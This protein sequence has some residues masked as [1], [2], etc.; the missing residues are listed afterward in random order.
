[1]LTRA[2]TP[3]PTIRLIFL[4]HLAGELAR[5]VHNQLTKNE[6]ESR[7]QIMRTLG[8]L[9]LALLLVLSVASPGLARM[10]MIETTVALQNHS[11]ESVKTAMTAAVEAAAR[12]A[13]AMGLPW[14]HL[15]RAFVLDDGVL[16][17]IFASDTKREGGEEEPERDEKPVRPADVQL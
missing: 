13:I 17:Q 9:A 5:G 1:M 3:S 6:T 4:G 10:A 12:G 16:I 7:R 11:E 15:R 8:L 2:N 14:I